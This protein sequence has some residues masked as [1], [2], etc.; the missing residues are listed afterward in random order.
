LTIRSGPDLLRLICLPPQEFNGLK[1]NYI[2]LR[3]KKPIFYLRNV[4]DL[5]SI[6]IDIEEAL[7]RLE[8]SQKYL[9]ERKFVLEDPPIEQDSGWFVTVD[10]FLKLIYLYGS[11]EKQ[12]FF[13]IR[14]QQL[15]LGN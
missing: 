10:G 8:D 6:K 2:Y 1:I 3:G 13:T 14:L 12:I 7:K 15:F 5:L 11:S 9:V 4:I